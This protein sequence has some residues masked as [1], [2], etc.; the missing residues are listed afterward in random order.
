VGTAT[1]ATARRRPERRAPAKA[2]AFVAT[3]LGVVFGGYAAERLL[4]EWRRAR[5]RRP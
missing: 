3:R 5:G 2:R 4:V 1:A